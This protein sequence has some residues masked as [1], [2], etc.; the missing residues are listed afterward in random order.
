MPE[1]NTVSVSILERDYRVACR[2][3][4]E[5][6]LLEAAKTLDDK[7]KEIKATGKVFGIERIAVMAA[8]NVTHELLQKSPENAESSAV[9]GRINSK[10]D[11]I[12]PDSDMDIFDLDFTD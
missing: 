11:A 12:L 3:G 1:Q 8:L 7:M 5:K 9:L 10:L 4:Q 2:P 6:N